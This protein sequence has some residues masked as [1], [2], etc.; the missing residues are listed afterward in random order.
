[1]LMI[2]FLGSFIGLALVTSESIPQQLLGGGI[3]AL[4]GLLGWAVFGGGA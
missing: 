1:M 4:M 3:L 2:L